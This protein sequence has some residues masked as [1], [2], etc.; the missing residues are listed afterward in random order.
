MEAMEGLRVGCV[1]VR[2]SFKEISLVTV[3]EAA[4]G[5]GEGER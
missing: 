2:F 3:W 4:L 5:V 1:L